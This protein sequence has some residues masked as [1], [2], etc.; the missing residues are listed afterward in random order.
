[1]ILRR[2]FTTSLLATAGLPLVGCSTVSAPQASQTLPAT[3]TGALNI[4]TGSVRIGVILPLSAPGN[5]GIVA[6]NLRNAMEL[7]LSETVGH[8]ISLIIKDDGGNAAGASG[9]AQALMSEGVEFVIGPLFSE[10]TRAAS[11]IITGAGRLM[12][13]FSTDPQ[14]A[15]Q[16]VYLLSFLAEPAINRVVRYAISKGQ[17]SF[18]ALV[19]NDPSGLIADAAFQQAVAGAGGRVMLTERFSDAAGMSAAAR[20]IAAISTT[21]NALFVPDPA[22][23][24]AVNALRQVGFDPAKIQYIGAG[25]WDGNAGAAAAAPSAIYAAP[26]GAAFRSFAARYRAKFNTDPVRIASL[27]YDAM[28]LVSKLGSLPKGN[29]YTEANFTGKAGFNGTDGLF[30][31]KTDG[32]NERGLAILKASGGIISPA[33]KAF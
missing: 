27:G 6:T 33:L 8:D 14:A 16:G 18:A 23:G 3:V 2:T 5:A 12:M 29:R 4:G 7:A 24:A 9:V 22:D 11:P 10:S 15:R 30:R 25:A 13:S 1:M 28:I 26:D 21:I 32:T 17:K 20:R 19:P 31:F